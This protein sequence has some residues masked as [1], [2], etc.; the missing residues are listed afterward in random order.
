M[1]FFKIRDFLVASLS[2]LGFLV[3]SA[4]G[5]AASDGVTEAVVIQTPSGLDVALPFEDT[6]FDLDVALPFEDGSRD[7]DNLIVATAENVN[8]AAFTESGLVL[9]PRALVNESLNE[10]GAIRDLLFIAL[11][12]DIPQ[13]ENWTF[14][15]L[16]QYHPIWQGFYQLGYFLPIDGPDAVIVVGDEQDLYDLLFGSFEYV[17]SPTTDLIGSIV[18]SSVS[19]TASG[20]TQ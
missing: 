4:C 18:T 12:E 11:G 14:T 1:T 20:A 5:N 3:L 7:Q 16:D 13:S 15:L 9:L 6:D 17:P 2:V 10:P 8:A 19:V